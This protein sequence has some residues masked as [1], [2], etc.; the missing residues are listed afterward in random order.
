MLRQINQIFRI[1]IVVVQIVL[2][3]VSAPVTAH[4]SPLWRWEM[5][6]SE[7]KRNKIHYERVS[8]TGRDS[9]RSSS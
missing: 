5:N 9:G 3:F 1:H 2:A 7:M 4:P 6:E 8:G